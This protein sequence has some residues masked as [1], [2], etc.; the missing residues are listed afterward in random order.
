MQPVSVSIDIKGQDIPTLICSDYSQ[1]TQFVGYLA[2]MAQS[3]AR[4]L[5]VEEYLFK[6]SR[7]DELRRVLWQQH[8]GL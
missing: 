6:P 4:S 1:R 2:D 3:V 7:V 5:G 8:P